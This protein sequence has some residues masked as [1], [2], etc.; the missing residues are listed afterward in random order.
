MNLT[1]MTELERLALFATQVRV[2][3]IHTKTEGLIRN[4]SIYMGLKAIKANGRLNGM[5]RAQFAKISVFNDAGEVVSV[6]G[7]AGSSK[8]GNQDKQYHAFNIREV[9]YKAATINMWMLTGLNVHGTDYVV[10]HIDGTDW[11]DSLTNLRIVHASV[12][13]TLVDKALPKLQDTGN[14]MVVAKLSI[15]GIKSLKNRGIKSAHDADML[16]QAIKSV[17]AYPDDPELLPAY[18]RRLRKPAGFTLAAIMKVASRL[19][20]GS[21]DNMWF[22]KKNRFTLSKSGKAMKKYM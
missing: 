10:D 13:H 16:L 20:N 2:Y 7:N 21:L 3:G 14:Y 4:K 17:T 12:N 19:S 15:F 6:N 9:K 11:N 18:L 1:T 22:N 8:N 5:T